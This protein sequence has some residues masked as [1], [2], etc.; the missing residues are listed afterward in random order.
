MLSGMAFL[1][2][3]LY[4]GKTW[5]NFFCPVSIVEKIY[6][7][8]SRIYPTQQTSQ[9]P[10]CTAC[11][12]HCPDI[13]QENHYWKEVASPSRRTAY[14]AFPGLVWAFYTAFALPRGTLQDYFGG[15]WAEV[16]AQYRLAT[17][18]GLWFAPWVPRWLVMPLWLLAGMAVSY[19]LFTLVER[20]LARRLDARRARHI[21]L[22]VAAFAAFISF[23]L[24]AGQPL[25]RRM[26]GAT[27][28]A[29]VVSAV[30][31]TLFL[32]HR[33]RRREDDFVEERSARSSRCTPTWC[34][35][36]W[37]TASSTS[38]SSAC[39]TSCAPTSAS[40]RRS[41]TRCWRACPSRTGRSST[42]R[43]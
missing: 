13:D 27:K 35:T 15:A 25:Y 32:L 40:R 7:E 9:C 2:G 5:C 43:G 16:P 28:L 22:T 6:T 12:K 4:T 24:F 29:S 31:A 18:P 38:R 26:T 8:P 21:S 34:A 37:P 19:F 33:W 30:V 10:R 23:Y 36:C 41:T 1:S 17:G 3:V 11:K 14:F 20:L 39:S 42:P